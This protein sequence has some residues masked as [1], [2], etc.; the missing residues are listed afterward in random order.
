VPVV[1]PWE[2]AVKQVSTRVDGDD[3]ESIDVQKLD[4]DDYMQRFAG[5][6]RDPQEPDHKYAL[7]ASSR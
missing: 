4:V 3:F 7:V 1:H 2:Y 5:S 6:G